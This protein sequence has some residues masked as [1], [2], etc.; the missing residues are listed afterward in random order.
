MRSDPADYVSELE[1]ELESDSPEFEDVKTFTLQWSDD[2]GAARVTVFK[3]SESAGTATIIPPAVS[4]VKDASGKL[5]EQKNSPRD[6]TDFKKS[7]DGTRVQGKT[8]S[9]G[10]KVTVTFT[11]VVAGSDSYLLSSYTAP[12]ASSPTVDRYKAGEDQAKAMVEFVKGLQVP[13]MEGEVGMRE[14]EEDLMDDS[15]RE[16]YEDDEFELELDDDD[17]EADEDEDDDQDSE[18]ELS[19]G[20]DEGDEDNEVME[21]YARKLNEISM[22]E[23]ENEPDLESALDRAIGGM[24]EE[25]FLQRVKRK[26]KHGKGKSIFG[27]ILKAGARIVGK[28]ASK[29]PVAGLVKAG[30]SLVRGDVRGALKNLGKAAVGTIGT[31]ILGPAGGALASSAVDALAGNKDGEVRQRRRRA[32]RRVARITRDAYKNLA[33]DLPPQIDDPYVA[34]EVARKAVRKAMVRHGLGPN[35]RPAAEPGREGRRIVRLRPGETLV[36]RG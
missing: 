4:L 28:V 33:D 5:T 19:G 9:W 21:N 32:I 29:L 35:A 25:Y 15:D 2:S 3:V 31:A 13:I 16:G 14:L 23:F 26:R 34:H 36:I 22:R 8:G 18:F 12:M 11:I 10:V 27:N 6:F 17:H 20:G 30:T 1:R 24:E 7:A